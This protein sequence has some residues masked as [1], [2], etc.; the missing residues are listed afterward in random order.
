MMLASYLVLGAMAGLLAGLLGV[1]G[2]LIIVPVLA[3]LFSVQGFSDQHLMHLAIGTSLA[4]I[5]VTALSSTLAHQRRGAVHWSAFRG[6][7]LGILVGAGAGALSADRLSGPML[8]ALFGV[9]ELV[10]AAQ[11]AIDRVPRAHRTLPGGV[12]LGVTGAGIGAV[13]AVL[14]IGGGTMTMP[15][16]LWCNVPV[17][18]AVGTSAACGLPIAAAGTLGFIISGHDASGL[19]PGAIGYVYAPAVAAIVAASVLGAPLG[20]SLAHKVQPSTL[21]RGFALFLAALGAR[22][23]VR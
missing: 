5:V 16:L 6:L 22:M 14:G 13:S 1:G 3:L 19:P 10:V 8:R 20:A 17:R 9:F 4:T 21:R 12:G 2:G 15:F 18:Q 23:L 7:S 11:L